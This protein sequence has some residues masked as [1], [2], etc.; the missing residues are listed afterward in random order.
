[1]L[2]ILAATALAAAPAPKPAADPHAAHRTTTAGAAK[3]EAGCDMPCCKGKP[4]PCC[5]KMMENKPAE[6]P[7]ADGHGGHEHD[8]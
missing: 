7:A 4:M 6:T 5:A 8:H 1:M 2:T 3:A